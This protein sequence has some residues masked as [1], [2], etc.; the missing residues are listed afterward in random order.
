MGQPVTH[1]QVLARN[2]E[3]AAQFYRALFGWNVDAG[4]AMGYRI[5]NTGAPTG[6]DGGIWP[7]PPEAQAMVTLY[8]EV[9]DV[10]QH[11]KKAVELGAKVAVPRQV[12][13]DGDEMAVVIDPEGIPFGLMR[14]ASR[15]RKGRTA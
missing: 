2:P 10:A 6:I 13:P 12:L 15:T 4:N 9:D 3:R 8:V 5:V 11:Y 7:A 1:W 14:R